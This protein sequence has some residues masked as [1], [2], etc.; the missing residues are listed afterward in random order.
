M[1]GFKL[2]F[3]NSFKILLLFIFVP[4]GYRIL[5]YHEADCKGKRTKLFPRRVPPKKCS[6]SFESCQATQVKDLEREK[7]FQVSCSKRLMLW[8][9]SDW[10]I[11][12]NKDRKKFILV[13]Q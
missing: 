5:W 13:T 9:T 7:I 3:Y 1:I 4:K 8:K 2:L 11:Q 12:K 10:V 6:H